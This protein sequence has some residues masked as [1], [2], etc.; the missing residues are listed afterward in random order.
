[1]FIVPEWEELVPDPTAFLWSFREKDVLKKWPTKEDQGKY[2]SIPEKQ[3]LK[4]NILAGNFKQCYY[5][6]AL[7]SSANV[8]NHSNYRFK[9][10]WKI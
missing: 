3:N 2:T 8:D 10:I 7:M 1:M 4:V 6:I 9:P 5:S